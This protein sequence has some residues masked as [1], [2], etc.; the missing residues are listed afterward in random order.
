MF[1]GYHILV[2]AGKVGAWW[3]VPA[4]AVLGG[5]G[6]YWRQ[7]SRVSGGLLAATLSH[8]AADLTVILAIYWMTVKI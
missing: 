5:A 2:L 4:F 1:A 7:I 8:M 3:L 6:W